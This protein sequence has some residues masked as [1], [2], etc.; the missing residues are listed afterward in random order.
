[1]IKKTAILFV[2]CLVWSSAV[3]AKLLLYSEDQTFHGCLDCSKYDSSSVCNQYANF[4]SRYS[5]DSIW[6]PYGIGSKYRSDSPFNQYGKGLRVEYGSGSLYGYF[7]IGFRGHP[8][9]RKTLQNIWGKTNGDFAM[10]R[11]LFCD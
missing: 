6:N 8:K 1:M 3:H 9:Y 4:G 5:Q 11:D 10:M 2:I 7:S